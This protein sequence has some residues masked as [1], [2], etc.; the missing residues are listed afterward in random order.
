MP[1]AAEP[2]ISVVIPCRNAAGTV[3]A[4]VRSAFAQALPPLEVIV[5]DDG[6]SDDSAAQ[7]EAAGAR[8]LRATRRGYA[9]GARN[10]GIEAARGECIAFMDADVEV[11]A[12]WLALA[13]AVLAAQPRVG[14][15][16]GR[17][18][19]GRGGLWGR[20]DHVLIF[21]EWMA[22]EARPC[23][24]F[25]TIAVVY[26]REAIGATR[27]PETNLA[28]DVFF[29]QAIQDKGWGAWYEPRIAIVHRHERLDAAAFWHR[30]VQ[31][32]RALYWSRSRLDRP[33]RFLVRAPWLMFALP[34]LW[35]VLARMLRGGAA[36]WA[37]VLL[38][39]L[40]AGE[41]ARGLGFLRG[42][43]EFAA[44]PLAA[45]GAAP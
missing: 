26:R 9:G 13:A 36:G 21:S 25:P 12:D 43:R 7:A 42:R 44:H 30:Q 15:V 34:H 2:T 20:L 17:I 38:P 10:L 24:A 1:A 33:G 11:A 14:A 40:V 32:G 8:V 3:G 5:V 41:V 29:C 39:W 16:G 37:V 45:A 27:F 6:S 18:H 23:S 22:G 28:E 19:D 4:A 31:A 35:I